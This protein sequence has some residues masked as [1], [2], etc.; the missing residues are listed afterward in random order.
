MALCSRGKGQLTAA[1]LL[2]ILTPFPFHRIKR[3]N[4]AVGFYNAK[5]IQEFQ[6]TKYAP[7]YFVSILNIPNIPNFLIILNFLIIQNTPIIPNVPITPIIQNIP[8]P[9]KK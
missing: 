2:G 7:Q 6:I 5:V 1:G 3:T 4:Y 9:P 8:I